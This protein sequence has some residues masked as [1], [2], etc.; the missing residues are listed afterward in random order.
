MMMNDIVAEYLP[1]IVPSALLLWLLKDVGS[2]KTMMATSLQKSLDLEVR[3]QKLERGRHDT[4][5]GI[6]TLTT[7]IDL[8]EWKGRVDD[9]RKDYYG[10][11]ESYPGAE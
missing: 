1:L 6:Q 11:K 8:L 7:R 9:N 2:L 3:V 10:S 5:D 4:N